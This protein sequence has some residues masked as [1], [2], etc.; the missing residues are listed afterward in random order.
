MK[1]KKI[2]QFVQVKLLVN[3]DFNLNIKIKRNYWKIEEF[4]ELKQKQKKLM[5]T[6]HEEWNAREI[7]VD[8]HRAIEINKKTFLPFVYRLIFYWFI[9]HTHIHWDAPFVVYRNEMLKYT[10]KKI[11]K[12]HVEGEKNEWVARCVHLGGVC[13]LR[14]A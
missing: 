5:K 1:C 12:F 4:I 8:H 9:T 3:L 14:Q 10:K 13:E 6:Y 7:D 11:K 2:F